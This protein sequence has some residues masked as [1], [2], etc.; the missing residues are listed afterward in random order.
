MVG[1]A[2]KP[3]KQAAKLAKIFRLAKE[4]KGMIQCKRV[5]DLQRMLRG[6]RDSGLK[7]GFVP[8]MG[9]LHDGHISLI[10]RCRSENDVAV[11]SIFVNPAQ[12]NNKEDFE[13]YPMSLGKDIDLLL[14]AQCD[15]VFVPGVPDM[16]PPGLPDKHFRIGK[17]EH[18][19]EGEFRPGHFQGVCKAVDRLLQI[20]QPDMLYLGRKDLQQCLVVREMMRTEGHQSVLVFGETVRERNG[21]AM[22]SRN[23]RLSDAQKENASKLYKHLETIKSIYPDAAA[24]AA[25]L[26]QSRKQLEGAGFTIE[27][28]TVADSLT[29]EPAGESTGDVTA[30]FAA[31]IDGVR[32]IDNIS[33]TSEQKA[34]H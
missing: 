5:T 33:V 19:L 15:I 27:Y 29:L 22:S 34:S 20:V 11:C 6:K 18:I 23:R 28:L 13:K 24:L 25:Q 7:I 17:L 14:R 9:A 21:L 1:R 8:T 12:F 10:E 32:L 3:Q 4:E 2:L 31:W 30:L 16:Y 26:Q